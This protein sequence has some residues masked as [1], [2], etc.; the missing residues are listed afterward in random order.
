M[1][2]SDES[3]SAAPRCRFVTIQAARSSP[4]QAL[5]PGACAST[6]PALVGATEP[7]SIT[8]RAPPSRY[9][10]RYSGGSRS[11]ALSA[12]S[13]PAEPPTSVWSS[14]P[15]SSPVLLCP[16]T[17]APEA[18]S[19]ASTRVRTAS[20]RVHPNAPMPITKTRLDRSGIRR[21]MMPVPQVATDPRSKVRGCS[22][23]SS[24]RSAC[25]SKPGHSKR[26]PHQ[27]SAAQ[28][29]NQYS[30]GDRCSSNDRACLHIQEHDPPRNSSR[31]R[32]IHM[33]TRTTSRMAPS[34]NHCLPP[35]PLPGS[36]RRRSLQPHMAGVPPR[37]PT[38]PRSDTPRDTPPAPRR[39]HRASTQAGRKTLL[40][41]V[42]LAGRTDVEVAWDAR[43]SRRCIR[44][45][46]GAGPVPY[47]ACSMEMPRAQLRHPRMRR[48]AA[49]RCPHPI[50]H[51][52]HRA[53]PRC[54]P[55]R[56]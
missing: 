8:S 55:C 26:N 45:G 36:H 16:P 9:A 18:C 31:A 51:L 46:K 29:D 4:P 23:A 41:Q 39:I 50:V 34:Y 20:P 5:T 28:R 33:C 30:Q 35:E 14:W 32:M 17:P 48:L 10:P 2:A 54:L 37:R 38:C 15:A 40:S 13:L 7:P 11:A 49:R 42:P 43:S 27:D 1:G 21:H 56:T 52:R 6:S 22:P 53:I 12:S 47:S 44:L 3:F 19:S 25:S 24:I